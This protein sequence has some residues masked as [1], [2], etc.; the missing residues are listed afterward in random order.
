MKDAF[1]RRSFTVWLSFDRLAGAAGGLR[2]GGL[3]CAARIALPKPTKLQNARSDTTVASTP[4]LS[5]LYL[6]TDSRRQRTDL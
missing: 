3:M 1:W 6:P 4:H 2:V 5:F